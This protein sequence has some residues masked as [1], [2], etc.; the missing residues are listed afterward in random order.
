[1][2][3]FLMILFVILCFTLALVI[4]MQQ[5]KGDMGL[6]G[7]GGG[8]QMLFGGS[9]GQ[10]F[11]EKITW[12]MGALF[13]FGALGLSILKHKESNVSRVKTTRTQE[14]PHHKTQKTK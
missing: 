6:G 5:G 12:A 3:I 9:G 4:L 1:M 11:F 13:I 14:Q 10:E 2:I 7:L 8:G